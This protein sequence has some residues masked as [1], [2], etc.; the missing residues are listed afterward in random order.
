MFGISLLMLVSTGLAAF[1]VNR[2]WV[3]LTQRRLNVKG[4][5]YDRASTP[6]LYWTTMS[7]ALLGLAFGLAILVLGLLAL[8]GS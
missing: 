5:I 2:L 3:G 4:A 8:V 6:I 1:M 7:I